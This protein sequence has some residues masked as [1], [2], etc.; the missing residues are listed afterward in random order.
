MYL[1]N[2]ITCWSIVLVLFSPAQNI[3]FNLLPIDNGFDFHN[4]LK[5]EE[6]KNPFNYVYAYNGG[7]VSI[8]DLNNDGLQD[9]F[10]TGN[11]VSSKLYLN[12]GNMLFEDATSAAGVMTE[13]WCSASTMIDINN[14][15]WL[16]IYVCRN[17]YDDP[18]LRENLLFLNN[19]DGTFSERAREF[20]INDSNYSG[21]ACFFDYD[22]D[23]DADLFVSNH[24]RY[25]L[26]A[27]S[28]HLNYIN[29]PVEK[30]SNHLYRNNGDQT[31][32]NV[33]QEAGLFDYSFSLG[34]FASDFDKDGDS[35]LFITVDFDEPDK[36][37]QNNGDGTFTDIIKGAMNSTSRFSMGIDGQDI[38]N[39]GKVDFF[40]AEMLN[41]D[42]VREKA[43]MAMMRINDYHFYVDSLKYNNFHMRNFLH[44][45]TSVPNNVHF[46]DV[47]RYA[48]VEKTDWSWS[49]LFFDADND[50]DYD[51]HISNGYYRDIMNRDRKRAL[52]STL[53]TFGKDMRRINARAKQYARECPQ[54]LLPNFL[55]E[56]QGELKFEDV[57]SSANVDQS[58]ISNGSAY[59]DLDNDGDLDL[60]I[61]NLAGRSFIYEN[62]SPAKN[63]LRIKLNGNSNCTPLGAKLEL[64]TSSGRIYSSE[65][66]N[67][68]GF[69]SSSEPFVH[70]GLGR[71]ERLISLEVTTIQNR[72]VLL[73]E[74]ELS[75]ALNSTLQ[76]D[77]SEANLEQNNTLQG[78]DQ[79]FQERDPKQFGLEYRHFEN[80][81]NDFEVQVLLP[82]KMSEMGPFLSKGD[83]NNDGKDDFFIG[84]PLGQP[85]QCFIQ[86][87]FGFVPRVYPA[88]VKDRFHEDA[89]SAFFDVDQDGD[90]DLLV[91]SGGYEYKD[92]IAYRPRLYINDGRGDLNERLGAFDG[93][94]S[95]ASC[96]EIC[97]IDLDGD[98]DVFIGARQNPG[99]YPQAGKSAIF[100]NDGTGKFLN[101]TK[102]IAPELESLG[103]ITDAAW[104]DIDKDGRD[105]LILVG[106]WMP[107]RIFTWKDE[108]L[109]DNTQTFLQKDYTGWWNTLSIGDINSDGVDDI[110]FGN[111]GLN[112]KFKA[113]ES[114]PFVMYA[115][116]FDKSGSED[117]ALAKFEG[118]V[119]YPVRGRACSVEQIPGL[120]KTFPKFDLFAS[121]TIDEIYGASLEEAKKFEVNTF[122]SIALMSK[123]ADFDVIELPALAQL[124]PI[125]S[126][127]LLNVDED[128]ELEVLFVGNLFQSE[129][130]TGRA[131]SG[132]GGILKWKEDKFEALKYEK[133]GLFAPNDAKSIL[134]L[135]HE[136]LRQNVLIIGNNNSKLQIFTSD[137]E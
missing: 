104:H 17:Y 132:I 81:F 93:W 101:K 28:A 118:E 100:L 66:I 8:G 111:L 63:F 69:Q 98:L 65:F 87:D 85:G 112:Y 15:G 3:E 21:V 83:L 51:L 29:N 97:D 103:M 134:H 46:S 133:H 99:K 26:I 14:D 45:N 54:T 6:L 53:S 12:K 116:D 36:L 72:K 126:I 43:E 137:L 1:K 55:F 107:I 57:K 4:T 24:P 52:D 30:Y 9:I 90:Q 123:S 78:S 121:A 89:G 114:K 106:E 27:Y 42:H 33:T 67:Q 80:D 76:I 64:K 48:G 95:S 16:D 34:A 13:G 56:N 68:R 58:T 59:G 60:V 131:D 130:E 109:E 44:L 94:L 113:N 74:S 22:G 120:K 110:I 25:R 125:N 71:E 37:M 135:V 11:M 117:I 129:I 39:D 38:N 61:N 49:P 40:V 115:D 79:I 32:S 127:K 86:T 75:S 82:H 88:F 119:L 23:G 124:A 47:S 128:D 2:V 91:A 84:G 102:E 18:K 77:L 122:S 73:S 136:T 5:E 10:I 62:V 70:F 92:E 19:Q 7:G 105:D 108:R 41:S 31:F 50:G 35:D 96:V 20:G